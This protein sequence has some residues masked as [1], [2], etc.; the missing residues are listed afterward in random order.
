MSEPTWYIRAQGRVTG[1]F[2]KPQLEGLRRK[3]KFARFHEV[4]QDRVTWTGA[5]ALAEI[6]AVPPRKEKD[7]GGSREG[8]DRGSEDVIYEMSLDPL[9]PTVPATSDDAEAWH[10]SHQGAKAIAARF[11]D[12]KRLLSTGE[13]DQGTLVWK[14]GMPGWVPCAQ[15]PGLRVSPATPSVGDPP[16]SW[17]SSPAGHG[18]TH[19]PHQAAGAGWPLARP[20]RTSGLA[21]TSLVLGLLW[22]CG[23]GS[24]LATIFGAVA[25]G[26][27]DRSHGA[28]TGRGMAVAGLILGIIGLASAL[29]PF[30]LPGF[31][32][33]FARGYRAGF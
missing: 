13:I 10:Y 7:D 14:S 21:V 15:V 26:Q 22:L 6:F 9:P 27:I 4:S 33:G 12:L 5:S 23:I 16:S 8:P 3:G 20:P 31:L 24:L 32:D 30:F 1:P 28:L 2:T 18:A 17:H 19:P 25:I 11:G 29:L